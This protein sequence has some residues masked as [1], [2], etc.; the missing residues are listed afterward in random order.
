MPSYHHIPVMLQE[1][2]DYLDCKSG[3]VYADC[4][5]G[6]AGHTRAILERITP[7][8]MVI[9]MDQDKDSVANAE[10][11]LKPYSRNVRIFHSNFI[12][13]SDILSQLNIQSVDGILLDLGLSLHQ[14]ESGGRGFSFKRDESLDMR[15]DIGSDTTAGDLV[16]DL[17]Q[18]QLEKIFKEYGEERWA[19]RIARRIAEVRKHR[20]IASSRQLSQIICDAIPRKAYPKKIHPATRVFMALRIAV[21]KELERLDSFMQKSA[22]LLK[23]GGR[24]CVLSFHSLEDRIVKHRMKEMEKEC[25]CPRSRAMPICT[26]NKE[27]VIRILTKKPRQPTAEEIAVNPM[28]RSTKLRAAERL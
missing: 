28:A 8:G 17:G 4:T 26:C 18:D 24:I 11:I 22:D 25:I 6:G 16:N 23:P 1:V 7:D 19:R 14:L 3:M 9:G 10:A 27:S 12:Y 5:L 13:L 15:M 21:N 20:R 2:I